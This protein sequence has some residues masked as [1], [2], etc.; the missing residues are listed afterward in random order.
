MNYWLIKTEPD[1][2]HWD[3]MVNDSVTFWDGI[4]NY[5]ARNYMRDMRIGDI[6]LFYHTG[7][8]R[9]A[10]GICTIVKEAYQDPTTNE[11]AWVAVDVQAKGPLKRPVS[12]DEIKAEPLLDG[13]ALVRQGRLSVVPLSKEEY[14]TII[15]MSKRG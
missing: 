1:V 4:R 3:T 5:Q 11:E 8:E 10:V 7:T 2:Y 12:L 13:I 6:A 15:A 9:R 14:D